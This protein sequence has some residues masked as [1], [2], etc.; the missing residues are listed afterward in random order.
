M[1]L[2][3]DGNNIDDVLRKVLANVAPATDNPP[4]ADA[5]SQPVTVAVRVIDG[6]IRAEDATTGRRWRIQSV[7]VNYYTHGT[8]GGIGRRRG[9][10]PDR[11]P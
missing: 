1:K 10:R 8:P 3:A 6:T 4:S 11:R 9:F 2:R 7:D 5:P